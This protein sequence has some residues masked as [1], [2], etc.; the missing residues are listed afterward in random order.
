MTMRIRISIGTLVLTLAASLAFAQ[1]L[2]DVARREKERRKQVDETGVEIVVHQGS[3]PPRSEAAV[4]KAPQVLQTAAS[5]PAPAVTKGAAPSFSLE[6]RDGRRYS[7]SQFKGRPVLIDFWASWCGPCRR[8]MPAI[9]QLYKKYRVQ[10]LQV[11]GINI[12]GRTPKALDYVQ[13]GGY[14]FPILFDSGNWESPVARSYG[15]RS[16]PRSFLL[17]ADGNVVF[18]GHPSSLEESLIEAALR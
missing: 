7:L 12:E 11:V 2:G 6:D 17:D 1:S 16:I 5:A 4:S 3:G 18:A 10:G 14:T 8:S 15:I 9:E 13:A